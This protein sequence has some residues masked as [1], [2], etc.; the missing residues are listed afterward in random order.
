MQPR[1]FISHSA[2]DPFTSDLLTRMGETLDKAGYDVL[3]DRTRLKIEGIG[4]NWRTTLNQWLDI[5]DGAI[6][7]ISPDAVNSTWVQSESTILNYRYQRDK[8]RGVTFRLLIIVTGAADTEKLKGAEFGITSLAD[9]QN[10]R[11]DDGK[12]DVYAKAL[13]IYSP[14]LQ[15]SDR[16]EKADLF[17]DIWRELKGCDDE[18]LIRAAEKLEKDFAKLHSRAINRASALTYLLMGARLEEAAAAVAELWSTRERK[19]D[20]IIRLIEPSWADTRSVVWLVEKF[21]KIKPP[22]IAIMPAVHVESVACH[23]DRARRRKPSI[24]W[25]PIVVPKLG[26]REPQDC[27][28]K[29]TS[30]LA[31]KLRVSSSVDV[32]AEIRATIEMSADNYPCVFIFPNWDAYAQAGKAIEEAFGPI[33]SIILCKGGGAALPADVKKPLEVENVDL[34]REAAFWRDRQLANLMLTS[35]LQ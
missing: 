10:V 9:I 8:D 35:L 4:S 27:L 31:D 1:I 12:V 18:S 14:L 32:A 21:A 33:T 11:G 17:F 26:D 7:L 34:N 13:E 3:V 29:L 25:I 20:N 28:E 6:L 16:S 15:S 22:R 19:Q 24:R 5:C 30:S 2:K 23:L